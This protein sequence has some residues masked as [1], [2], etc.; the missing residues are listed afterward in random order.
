MKGNSLEST[1][2]KVSRAITH[3]YGLRLVCEG[4]R[5]RTNGRTI[6]LPSLPE[7]VPED[8]LGAI[9]GWADHECS[10]AIYT[11][12][13]LGPTFRKAHGL[14]AFQILNAL[15]DARVERLMG[16][17]YP[18]A[19]LNLEDA[20]GFVADRAEEGQVRTPGPFD[21]FVSALYTRASGRPDQSWISAD[22]YAVADLCDA[23]LSELR[24]CRK[25]KDVG[26]IALRIW[27]KLSQDFEEEARNGQEQNP[28]R[29]PG[30][31]AE[32]GDQ[33]GAGPGPQ[34]GSPG[35]KSGT[36]PTED[37][38]PAGPMGQLASLIEFELQ[39]HSSH[40]EGVYR[41]YTLE[42]DVVEVPKAHAGFDYRKE[43]EEL[44]P[45]V[46]GLRRRLLHTLMARKETRW[47]GDRTRGSLDPRSLHRLVTCSS[48]RIFRK[49]VAAEAK[50]T[51]C[52]LLL[53]LSSSMSGPAIDMCQKLS[54]L[55]GE[56]L[57][58][59]GFPTEVIGFSTL[60]A[61]V[62]AEVARETGVS[63]EELAKRFSRFVPLYHSVF[64]AFEEPWR[65]VTGRFGAM[66]TKSLTPLGESLL[67]AGRR[68]A[69]RPESRKVLFCLTDGKPVVGAWDEQITFD[70]SCQCVQRLSRAAIEVVG[71]GIMEQCVASIFPRHAVI[72]SLDELPKG[73]LRQLCG[74]LGSD[75]CNRFDY[76]FHWLCASLLSPP[77]TRSRASR[78]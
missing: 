35:G 32:G 11:Q 51:A 40:S 54:I 63:E 49:H 8:L 67:F 47:L 24:S 43:I 75:R 34:P 57:D 7:N 72:R 2:E 70:H 42:N 14:Q 55:F 25:T 65:K 1:L 77:R 58:M 52:T 23:E 59:L 74:V 31:P 16:R 17:R 41:V 64:K 78:P 33:G 10:H 38:Q 12:T 29:E 9:R 21:Q 30:N 44:R 5:C 62:R 19:R 36:A 27:E 48:S 3:R 73:F 18:G 4:D 71:I 6:Y 53:D 46:S 13:T 22:A 69:L 15:E 50:N 37:Q 39:Q 56:T 26:E 66:G 76:P 60:D 45:Y 68:L 61:D 28:P 20:F